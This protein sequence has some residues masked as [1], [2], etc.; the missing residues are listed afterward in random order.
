M[1]RLLF[2]VAAAV[3]THVPLHQQH[4]C[5][6]TL[7]SKNASVQE[8][9]KWEAGPRSEFVCRH[10]MSDDEYHYINTCKNPGGRVSSNTTQLPV[11]SKL[12]IKCNTTTRT[13]VHKQVEL[14]VF[15]YVLRHLRESFHDCG[16]HILHYIFFWYRE[17]SQ[18]SWSWAT[19]ISAWPKLEKVNRRVRRVYHMHQQLP[20]KR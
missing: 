13:V 2:T 4:S 16:R 14:M 5:L 18:V 1:I 6:L 10:F 3:I 17:T 19:R 7:V 11:K 8:R 12:T 9:L 15:I 20:N